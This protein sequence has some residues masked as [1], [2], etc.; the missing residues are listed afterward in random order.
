MEFYRNYIEQIDVILP[1]AKEYDNDFTK[2][3]G[4]SSALALEIPQAFAKSL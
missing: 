3:C 2:A 4:I 1:F